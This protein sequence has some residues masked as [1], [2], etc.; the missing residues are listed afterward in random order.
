[1][2]DT[3]GIDLKADNFKTQLTLVINK[4]NLPP[5]LVL[6]ILKDIYYEVNDLYKQSV[7]KQYQDF[8]ETEKEEQTAAQ[9]NDELAA[10]DSDNIDDK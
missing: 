7:S 10:A 5:S 8:C 2:E 3:R 4:S 6:Y 1:M 9:E